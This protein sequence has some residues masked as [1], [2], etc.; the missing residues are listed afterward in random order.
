MTA[1]KYD[2]KEVARL[3]AL[4]D[5][6]DQGPWIWKQRKEL[7]GRIHTLVTSLFGP[8]DK[9]VLSP[10]PLDVVCDKSN[11]DFIASAHALADQLQAAAAVIERQR[12]FILSV[13]IQDCDVELEMARTE[14]LNITDEQEKP[15]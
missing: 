9:L 14:I 2:A 5:V 4:R 3:L 7:F 13:P 15:A 8:D 1:P 10:A 11:R 6:A 12:A